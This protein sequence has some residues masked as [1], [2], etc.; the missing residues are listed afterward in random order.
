I[1]PAIT[2]DGIVAYDVVPGS[3]TSQKFLKFLECYIHLT[4]PYPGPHSVIIMDN[5]SIHHAEEVRELLE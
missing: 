2:L 1:L 3:V 5:C 4:N